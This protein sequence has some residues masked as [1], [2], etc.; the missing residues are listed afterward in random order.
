[1]TG[2]HPFRPW[3]RHRPAAAI[4]HVPSPVRR[5][6]VS[7]PVGPDAVRQ[8]REAMTQRFSEVGVA[9]DSVFA[10]AVLL[11]VSEL[12]TNVLRHAPRSP[13]ADVG[14]T[15]GAG[16]LVVSVAD[17][18]PCLP[19]LEP[20]AMGAGLELVAE[21]AGE[22]D[23]DVSAEPAVGRDGKVVLVRFG[24]PSRAMDTPRSR[25]AMRWPGA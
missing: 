12:V 4:E 20:G 23:G 21:L 14:M 1:M 24:L 3:R 11:V 19:D 8:A 6:I 17:A 25:E 9:S 13:V 7:V 10:D 16:Q 18:E 2:G 15:V 5:H 22:Y